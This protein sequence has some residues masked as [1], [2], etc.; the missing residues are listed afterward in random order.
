LSLRTRLALVLAVM[1]LTPLLATWLA[2]G[3]LVPRTVD[4][5]TTTSVERSVGSAQTVL[6][7]QC[8]GLA[9]A[10]R[11]LAADLRTQLASG[12]G[13]TA[14]SSGDAAITIAADRPGITVAVL[15]D[16]RLIA[17]AGPRVDSLTAETVRQASTSSCSSRSTGELS[18]PILA[19]SVTVTRAGTE[20]ALAV[21]FRPLDDEGLHTLADGLGLSSH[22]MLLGNGPEVLAASDRSVDMTAVA[23]EVAAGA[24]HG[25]VDRIRF[26]AVAEPAGVPYTLVAVEPVVG[27]GLLAWTGAAV[28]VA[29]VASALLVR[30]LVGRLTGPLLRVTGAAER[31]G[32]GDLDARSGVNGGDEVGRLATTFDA[33]AEGLQVKVAE[34]EA[35]RDALTD[36]FE[37]FGEALGRTHDIDGLLYTVVEAAMRGADATVGTALLGDNRHLEERA[38][39]VRDGGP[40]SVIGALDDLHRLSTDAIRRGEPAI[41]DELPSAGAAIAVPLERDG[42]AIGALAIARGQDGGPLDGTAVRAVRA[43]ATH[44]GTAVANVRAH[45]ETRRQSMTDPLTGVGNFRQLTTT[46]GREVERAIRFHRPLSVLML[47]LDH[48]KRVNDSRGH[49]VGD[50]VLREFATRLHGCLREV[51]VVARYGGEEFAVILPETGA[52]G[53]STV[54]DRV[55]SAIRDEPFTAIG[56]QLRITVSIG[57]ASFPDHGNS[58]AEVMRSADAALYAAKRA[59]RDR[60]RLAGSAGEP[61]PVPAAR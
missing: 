50:A 31:F 4:H 36:T 55:L 26:R 13:I 8:A 51:D 42:R 61:Q 33:M 41:V 40:S 27:A 44:A 3:I 14:R 35:S 52:P 23:R 34:L 7:T 59:G 47:D 2:V 11:A 19:E 1:M 54:A 60:W 10:A 30:I 21:A 6:A 37:R 56:Q 48:F 49:A 28:A 58:A 12:T 53:A 16:D 17:D 9:D 29:V 39:A 45:E 46:L 32:S 22:L 43:L 24:D 18:S 57:A 15:L 20:R 5:V 25:R 38:T